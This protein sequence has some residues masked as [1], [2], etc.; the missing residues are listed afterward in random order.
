MIDNDTGNKCGFSTPAP[1][2]DDSKNHNPLSEDLLESDRES[3]NESESNSEES[4]F[5]K[6]D[7]A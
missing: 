7:Q 5:D 4:I 6:I 3:D 1:A 2:S